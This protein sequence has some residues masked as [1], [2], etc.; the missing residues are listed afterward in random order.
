MQATLGHVNSLGSGFNANCNICGKSRPL[1]MDW[2]IKRY[3]LDFPVPGLT[4]FL[5]V[6]SLN[7]LAGN[8]IERTGNKHTTTGTYIGSNQS[9]P[10]PTPQVISLKYLSR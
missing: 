7:Q 3:G 6:N 2:L 1:D 8:L 9:R 10:L 5:K 4:K